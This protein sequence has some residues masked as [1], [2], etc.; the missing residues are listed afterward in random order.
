MSRDVGAAAGAG[1]SGEPAADGLAAAPVLGEPVVVEGHDVA[2][3]A[4]LVVMVVGDVT[5][6]LVGRHFWFSGGEWALLAQRSVSVSGLLEPHMGHLVALPV[7]EYRALFNTVGL[8]AYWPFEFIAIGLHLTAACLLRVVMR[9]CGV[10]PWIA[11]AAATL[12]VFFG[13]GAQNIVWGLQ[14]SLT[15][16]L[17]FGLVQLLC[18]DH[19][20]GVDRRD[21]FGLAAGLAALACSGVALSIIGVVGVAV[22]IR[23]GWKPMLFHVGPLAGIYIVWSR[24]YNNDAH[25]SFRVGP[26]FRWS[27]RGISATF[28]ALTQVPFFGWLLATMLVVGLVLAFRSTAG[29]W[30]QKAGIPV[31]FLVGVI[32]FEVTNGALRLSVG[33]P[34]AAESR[35]LWVVGAL[36]LV[37]LAV[38][39][40]AIARRGATFGALAFVLLL[41]GVPLNIAHIGDAFGDTD[42]FLGGVDHTAY[43]RL[44]EELPRHEAAQQVPQS[45]LPDPTRNPWVTVGWL[46]ANERKLSRAQPSAAEDAAVRLRLSIQQRYIA[47][48]TGNCHTMT[49]SEDYALRGGDYLDTFGAFSIASPPSTPQRYGMSLIGLGY[50]QRIE[51][52]L[53]PVHLHITPVMVSGW[54]APSICTSQPLP[55]ARPSAS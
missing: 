41:V 52:T 32:G 29:T 43:Q 35:Y 9:R 48:L 49:S 47:Q 38:A 51:P 19:D 11:T 13:A 28:D 33:I 39:A 34:A 25:L 20:G 4:F 1:T 17:V 31:A 27:A 6:A 23:R 24:R 2:Y 30:R 36:L 44:I 7:L 16:A 40:D 5:Y 21:W 50:L 22:L 10:G 14:A 55:S 45:L 12:F 37:P 42:S 26:L 8:H 53:G 3:W 18:A 46:R 15:G 54:P